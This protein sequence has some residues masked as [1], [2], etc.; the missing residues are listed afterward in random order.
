MIFSSHAFN[1][2]NRLSYP[3]FAFPLLRLNAS[4]LL[5]LHSLQLPTDSLLVGS[6][7]RQNTATHVIFLQLIRSGW[8]CNDGK[9]THC[10]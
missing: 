4:L 6:L 2:I 7:S 1:M 9:M 10:D 5:L 8:Y 3:K